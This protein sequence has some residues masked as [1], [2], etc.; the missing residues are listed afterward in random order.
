MS[1]EA[2]RQPRQLSE[3]NYPDVKKL[4][5]DFRRSK[6]GINLAIIADRVLRKPH[7]ENMAP[8]IPSLLIPTTAIVYEASDFSE[9]IAPQVVIETDKNVLQASELNSPLLE[10]RV[11]VIDPWINDFFSSPKVQEAISQAETSKEPVVIDYGMFYW[12]DV[13]PVLGGV[14]KV[15]EYIRGR[16]DIL[17][18]VLD[19]SGL[20]HIQVNLIGIW[21]FGEE[22]SGDINTDL[23]RLNDQ[24]GHGDHVHQIRD[25]NDLDFVGGFTLEGGKYC[26]MSPLNKD[27]EFPFSTIAYLI[28]AY[29]ADGKI[30]QDIVLAHEAAQ[31]MGAGGSNPGTEGRG[32]SA[33]AFLNDD[34]KICTVVASNCPAGYT[35]LKVLS[36][37]GVWMGFIIGDANHNNTLAVETV[38]PEVA[39]YRPLHRIFLPAIQ[40]SG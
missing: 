15:E 11:T 39:V 8:L 13:V 30:C 1:V 21:A 37:D 36:R 20:E 40:R 26:G 27:S 14:D 19:N 12:D 16:D 38:A 9:S 22:S 35:R 5:E 2:I 25:E 3:I 32:G 7:L 18:E 31:L 17:R 24:D 34:Q 4:W 28:M 23:S 10:S 33:M 6:T 29:Q